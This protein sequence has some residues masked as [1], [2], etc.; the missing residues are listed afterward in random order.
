MMMMM[1]VQ[2]EAAALKGKDETK[3]VALGIGSGVYE[4]ELRDIASSP[5]DVILVQDFSSLPS[6][7]DRLLNEICSGNHVSFA[8]C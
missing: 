7:E 8:S 1:R 2:T 3:V 6:V 5:H 4:A